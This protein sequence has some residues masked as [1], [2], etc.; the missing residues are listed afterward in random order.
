MHVKPKVA[1]SSSERGSSVFAL[2]ANNINDMDE[3][4]E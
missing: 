2:C 1:T 3:V 4:F